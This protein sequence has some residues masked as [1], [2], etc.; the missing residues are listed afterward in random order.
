MRLSLDMRSNVHSEG[1]APVWR[2]SLSTV[3]LG[4][5]IFLVR[6]RNT[7]RT[8]HGPASASSAATDE[9]EECI[10]AAGLSHIIAKIHKP[11]ASGIGK[12]DTMLQ[13]TLAL[14]DLPSVIDIPMAGASTKRPIAKM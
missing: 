6:A 8:P 4:D 11:N 12:R 2:A 5:N 7:Q 3:G 14:T 1:R 13:R 10:P 9:Y